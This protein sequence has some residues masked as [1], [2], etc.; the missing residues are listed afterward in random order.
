MLAEPSPTAPSSTPGPVAVRRAGAADLDALV[1][2]EEASFSAD[3]ISRRQYRRHLA[4]ASACVLVAGSGSAPCLGSALVFFRRGSPT[5]RL[6]SLAIR[7]QARG[8]GLGAAL[9]EAAEAE[10]RSRGCHHMRLEVRT[11]NLPA[12]ALYERLGY[13]RIGVCRA[14]YA[15]GADGWRY[16]KALARESGR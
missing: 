9:I 10:A 2:L 11:D 15:D 6:Y 8:R 4:S 12:I 1:A 14:Y 5:A 16:A 13:R 3:R 7:A